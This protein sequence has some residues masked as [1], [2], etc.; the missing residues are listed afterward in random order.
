MTKSFAELTQNLPHRPILEKAL[1][2]FENYQRSRLIVVVVQE[3]NHHFYS[4]IILKYMHL[5]QLLKLKISV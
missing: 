2:Y 4:V 3:M 1:S 5:I